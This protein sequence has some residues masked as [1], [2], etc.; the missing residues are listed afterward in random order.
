MLDSQAQPPRPGRAEHEPVGAFGKEFLR[1]GA[2]EYL[3]IGPMILR[4]DTA[5]R[6]ARRAASLENIGRLV[7][8]GARQP[9]SHRP[10]AQPVVLEETELSQVF[11]ALDLLPRVEAQ[12]QEWILPRRGI[13]PE[14]RPG[15]RVEMPFD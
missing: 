5:L 12:L 1:Q 2:A 14:R 15:F 11:E 6:D 4:D 10:A 8:Q 3:V 13:D 9:P 7:P